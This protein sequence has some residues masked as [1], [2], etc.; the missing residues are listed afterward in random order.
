MV[1]LSTDEV[2]LV[3]ARAAFSPVHL[4]APP[5]RRLDGRRE[6]RA[7]GLG[8]ALNGIVRRSVRED[9]AIV[10][11]VVLALEVGDAGVVVAVRIRH[12][13]P[14]A[15]ESEVEEDE[16][17]AVV[18]HRIAGVV[19]DVHALEDVVVYVPDGL[20]LVDYDADAVE[21][22]APVGSVFGAC[23]AGV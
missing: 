17:R 11:H 22:V 10:D 7:R 2:A 21:G 16:P 19:A 8:L 14:A 5:D 12:P 13:R 18:Q 20:E 9:A 3:V 4:P 1:G 23:E 6:L 15:A